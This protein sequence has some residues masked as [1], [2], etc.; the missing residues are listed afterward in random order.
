VGAA[1]GHRHAG[2]SEHNRIRRLLAVLAL[3]GLVSAC[4]SDDDGDADDDNETVAAKTGANSDD[5]TTTSSPPA[6]DGYKIDEVAP[7]LRD[8]LE[9]YDEVVTE[10]VADPEVADDEDDPLVQE[11]LSLFEPGSDF[12]AGSLE[13]WERYAGTGVTLAPLADG[14][15]VNKTV[16]EGA[17]TTVDEDEVSFGQCT[18]LQYVLHRNGE[19]AERTDRK[20]LPG[21][22]RAVRVD[23][24]WRLVD[25]STPPDLRGCLTQG[26][27]SQ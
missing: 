20:L 5:T 11:F 15:T 9:R 3:L 19:E 21:N 25:I 6:P 23:G 24:E 2:R 27:A 12:A 16:L 4:S 13:G 1:N 7:H 10:I 8:L 26:G 14:Q 18:V 22:G 17:V